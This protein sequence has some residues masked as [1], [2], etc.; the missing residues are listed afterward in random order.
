MSSWSLQYGRVIYQ[1]VWSEAELAVRIRLIAVACLVVAAAVLTALSPVVLKWMVDGFAAGNPKS[2][3][4]YALALIFALIQFLVRAMSEMRG[5][6]YAGAE[7][8]TM[9][10]LSENIFMHLMRL[11]LRFHLDRRTGAVS[12]SLDLGLQGYQMILH[13][14]VFTVLPV[15]A[16][17]VTIVFVL[18]RLTPP[19][20]VALFCAALACYGM[21]FGCA[22]RVAA[23]SAKT[24]S[25][26]SIDASAKITDGLLNYEIVKYFTA[27][28]VVQDGVSRALRRAEGLWATFYR[29]HAKNGLLLA[30]IYGVVLCATLVMATGDVLGGQMTVGEFVLV[31][32]YMLQVLRPVEMLGYALQAFAQGSAMLHKMLELF[33]QIPET[34][35]VIDRAASNC[36]NSIRF[37]N[38][39]LSYNLGHRVLRSLNFEVAPGKTLGIVGASGSGKS[40]IVRLAVRLLD[41]DSGRILVGAVPINE[42]SLAI[43][44]N[45]I[46]V[47]PQDTVLLNATI[48]CNIALGRSACSIGELEAAAKLASLHEFIMSLPDKYD[49]LVGERGVKLS[50][51][52]RQRLAIARAVIRRPEIYIFDEATSSLDSG[53]ESE[54]LRKVHEIARSSTTLII[55][56]RLSSV[57]HADEIIVLD[58]G[59]IVE[60]GLHQR[61]VS[62]QGVYAALWHAQHHDPPG[63]LSDNNVPPPSS[64]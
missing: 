22:T 18:T 57:V 2:I 14:L 38:V 59:R 19:T 4:P 55:A 62:R 36:L 33:E 56:H 15:T 42:L 39:T 50:G 30:I 6:I 49:T 25:T 44:R 54:I 45:A 51:G 34:E 20:L 9:R 32:A 11:P 47:V 58:A 48:A 29:R 63:L 8:R 17:L 31:N 27:E 26:A 16:E 52:E 5:L 10:V 13:H 41:P 23:S 46:A 21:A 1:I 28:L 60:Q 12:H 43:L 37:D 24:A 53:T 3:S 7:R 61:L 35:P 40:T 64:R